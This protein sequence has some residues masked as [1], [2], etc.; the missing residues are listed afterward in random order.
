M[1]TSRALQVASNMPFLRSAPFT[2]AEGTEPLLALKQVTS[3]D[4]KMENQRIFDTTKQVAESA[5]T[6]YEHAIHERKLMRLYLH[7]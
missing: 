6:A 5:E 4:Q 3:F 7:S 2:V 1:T